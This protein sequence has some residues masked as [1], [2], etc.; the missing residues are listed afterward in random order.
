MSD[1]LGAVVVLA[2]ALF[3]GWFGRGRS[4]K[5]KRDRDRVKNREIR[6][7]AFDDAEAQ[8]DPVLIDRLTR[9]GQ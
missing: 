7:A 3:A 2:I 1:I 9:K 5:A 8:S 6:D 4:E